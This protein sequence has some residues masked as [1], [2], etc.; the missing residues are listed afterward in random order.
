VTQKLD[1]KELERKVFASYHQDGL[2][3]I[4]ACIYI[5]GFSI[6]ILLD[7]LWDF[8]LGVLLP[9]ILVVLV[10]PL[11]IKAKRKITMPRIGYV[12]FGT[13]GKTKITV[14]FAGILVLGTAFFF[15]FALYIESSWLQFI[16]E[17]G[18]IEVGIGA[19]LVSSLFGYATGVKRLYVY[20][21]IALTL[22][23]VGYFFEIFFAYIIF[24]L[25]LVVLSVGIALLIVFV[26]KYPAKGDQALA[27]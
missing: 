2:I 23:T 4:F 8:S 10:V 21:M 3:D 5:I 9:G 27:K 25:G 18:M 19:L 20:G 7:Y 15:A 16:I 11:W 26:R 24:V 13:R 6:G 12:N 14:I 22:F 1:L 17:N